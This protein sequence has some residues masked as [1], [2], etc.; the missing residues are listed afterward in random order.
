[1]ILQIQ[2]TVWLKWYDATVDDFQRYDLRID[3]DVAKFQYRPTWAGKL[4]LQIEV[5]KHHS[6][7]LNGSGY[8]EDWTTQNWRDATFA[9]VQYYHL[10]QYQ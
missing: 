5:T 2:T 6:I 3:H 9:D 4:V 7:D 1:M 8:F 10:G